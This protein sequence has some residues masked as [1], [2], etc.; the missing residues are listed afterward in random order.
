VA[1]PLRV[2]PGLPEAGD[3]D[4]DDGRVDRADSLVSE[5]EPGGHAGQEVLHHDICPPGELERNLRA[6]GMLEI[7][8]DAPLVAIDGREG[9][10]HAV[11]AAQHAQVVAH[12]RPLQLNPG[13]RQVGQERAHVR[14]T[15]HARE[16]ED[17]DAFEHAHQAGM[18]RVGKVQSGSMSDP[19][20][21]TTTRPFATA[22]CRS[23]RA[24][25]TGVRLSRPDVAAPWWSR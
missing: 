4:V 11:L 7:E 22:P 19:E 9:C 2:R 16:V 13:F 12:W 20:S 3:G 5:P 8:G 6:F 17:A 14:P 24:G 10:A 21:G 23:A 1:R 18:L 25:W 15:F